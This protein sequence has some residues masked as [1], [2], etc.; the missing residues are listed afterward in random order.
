M[1]KQSQ[2]LISYILISHHSF[3]MIM[4]AKDIQSYL[5]ALKRL[6]GLLKKDGDG[7][8]N[9]ATDLL[10][11]QARVLLKK[12]LDAE[13]KRILEKYSELQ[14]PR[15]PTNKQPIPLSKFSITA[16]TYQSHENDMEPEKDIMFSKEKGFISPQ[17]NQ[18]DGPEQL[19]QSVLAS[20]LIQTKKRCRLCQKN[21]IN[22]MKPIN[23]T[24]FYDDT[25]NSTKSA[26]KSEDVDRLSKEA[27]EAIEHI[28]L[29]MSALRIRA[30]HSNVFDKS[31]SEESFTSTR[32]FPIELSSQS[33]MARPVS[34]SYP[35]NPVHYLA[36]EE[37]NQPLWLL[38][39]N[40]GLIQPTKPI[41]I[42]STNNFT[43][44][45]LF[46]ESDASTEKCKFPTKEVNTNI[47]SGNWIMGLYDFVPSGIHNV[48]HF[49]AQLDPSETP[50]AK[51]EAP[52]QA[53]KPLGNVSSNLGPRGKNHKKPS[54]DEIR[55]NRQLI[56]DSTT[57]DSYSNRTP[58]QRTSSRNSN[59]EEYSS[60]Y[61][62][63]EYATSSTWS[64]SNSGAESDYDSYTGNNIEGNDDDDN[65]YSS[66]SSVADRES[67][68]SSRSTYSLASKKSG[69]SSARKAYGKRKGE[70][71]KGM[72]RRM[73]DKM[74]FIFHHHH[75][76]HHHHH[77]DDGRGKSK[78]KTSRLGKEISFNGRDAEAYG[79]KAVEKVKK[80]M[81][82]REKN[83][84]SHFH[85]LMEGLLRHVR[86]SKSKQSKQGKETIGKLGKGHHER[87]T[88]LKKSHW[89]KVMQHQRR[90]KLTN[91]TH[92]KLGLGKKKAR[93]KALPDMS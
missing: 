78:T 5:I 21:T 93:L 46:L 3:I 56:W 48:R 81:M 30:D 15:E 16:E 51:I 37:M 65:V 33:T 11:E 12:L 34:C 82:V 63:G 31:Q 59:S 62:K 73:K 53:Y 76:H 1:K 9:S 49:G 45:G 57:S 89:W 38:D 70:K 77:D 4:D 55:K 74:S 6:Y 84:Q 83:Q 79:E 24:H 35:L 39:Q 44:K 19:T 29:C 86:H 67:I 23:E 60:S 13:T 58:S 87:Q 32:N 25:Q 28:E 40:L 61:R 91:K 69:P 71:Q 41:S 88:T 68:A 72:W 80:S 36:V 26:N 85:G 50:Y 42:Q 20:G 47:Q 92:V 52:Y 2:L 10:D 14:Q 22:Q 27:S 43:G 7:A 64:S 90:N 54:Q 18:T 75:H 66:T 17:W 8:S